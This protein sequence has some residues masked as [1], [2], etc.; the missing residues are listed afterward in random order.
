H[1]DL[2]AEFNTSNPEWCAGTVIVGGSFVAKTAWSEPAGIRVLR[3]ARVLAALAEAAPDLPIPR[4]VGMSQDP[5][6]F[7]TTLVRGTPLSHEERPR[8]AV[9]ASELGRFLAGL[10]T[11]AV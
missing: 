6:A 5:V 4:L 7:V 2:Q 10:H 3:E 9:V 8:W 11:Q 1:I